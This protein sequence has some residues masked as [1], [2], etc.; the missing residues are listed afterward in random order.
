M[1][2]AY[3]V[4]LNLIVVVRWNAHA[5]QQMKGASTSNQHGG[6]RVYIGTHPL[7]TEG[8][9]HCQRRSN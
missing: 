3:A 6:Q 5:L 9:C 1:L 7:W 4:H 2:S 8:I